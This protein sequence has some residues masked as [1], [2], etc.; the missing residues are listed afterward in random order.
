MYVY[1]ELLEVYNDKIDHYKSI[2]KCCHF[3]L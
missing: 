1:K 2:T 3:I